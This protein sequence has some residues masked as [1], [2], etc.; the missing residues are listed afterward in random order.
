M[1]PPG[2]GPLAT[3][4]D[5]AACFRL[6]LGRAPNPEEWTGHSSRAG[7]PLAQV[8]GSYVNSLEFARRRLQDP[9]GTPPQVAALEGFRILAS[10]DDLAVGVDVLAGCY[11]PDVVAVFRQVLRPGMTVIDVGANIGVFTMLAASLVG[12]SGRVLAVEPNPLNARMAEAS[13]RLNGFDHVTVLQA[14]AGPGAGMLAINTSFSNGTTAAIDDG[15][16]MQADTVACVAVD[17]VAPAGRRVDLVK[18]DV[19]GAEYTALQ[20]CRR[21][22]RRDRPVLVFEFTPGAL[23][24]ISGISGEGLLRWV[25]AQGYDLALIRPGAPPEPMGQDWQGVMRRYVERGTDHVDIVARPVGRWTR[26]LGRAGR[27]PGRDG[28]R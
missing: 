12:P 3:E 13:R 1:T 18:L 23:P 21:L 11:E 8:V 16:V 14:A 4:A 27:R 22:L 5:I 7:E 19:E 17:Q 2:G 6:I 28:E 20:G 25:I 26:L 9:T 15:Q 24:G 10:P